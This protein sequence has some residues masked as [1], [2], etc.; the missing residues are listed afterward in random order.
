L[1]RVSE[2][3]DRKILKKSVQIHLEAD[4]LRIDLLS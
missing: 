2:D 1:Y 3:I 4:R